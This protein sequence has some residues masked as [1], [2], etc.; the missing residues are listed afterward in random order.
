MS[1]TDERLKTLERKIGGFTQLLSKFESRIDAMDNQLN[2]LSALTK[3]QF[4][5][6]FSQLKTASDMLEAI[7]EEFYVDAEE[8]EE[9]DDGDEFPE[10]VAEVLKD[11]GIDEEELIPEIPFLPDE[12]VEEDEDTQ[13]EGDQDGPE[14]DNA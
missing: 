10:D 3:E 9:E 8:E 12:T 4:S 7:S 1:Q 2:E 6:L 14:F 5:E 13:D 11:M